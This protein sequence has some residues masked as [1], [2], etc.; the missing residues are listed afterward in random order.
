M[1]NHARLTQ[2]GPEAG[3]PYLEQARYAIAREHLDY[4]P[5]TCAASGVLDGPD[6]SDVSA[7]TTTLVAQHRSRSL[8]RRPPRSAPD[9]CGAR[10]EGLGSGRHRLPR[11]T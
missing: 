2:G 6:V 4:D 11:V 8:G 1:S 10:R 3:D 9:H 7:G 5:V